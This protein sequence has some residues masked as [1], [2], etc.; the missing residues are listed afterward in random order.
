MEPGIID[1]V[2][3]V[4]YNIFRKE[5]IIE[6]ENKVTITLV[7]RPPSPL[8]KTLEGSRT[9][10]AFEMGAEGVVSMPLHTLTAEDY[11]AIIQDYIM[12]R[13]ENVAKLPSI[14]SIEKLLGKP[15]IQDVLSIEELLDNCWEI[16]VRKSYLPVLAEILH[17]KF[18]GSSIDNNYISWKPSKIYDKTICRALNLESE[19]IA[20]ERWQERVR[21]SRWTIAQVFYIHKEYFRSKGT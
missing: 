4:N 21:K 5:Y 2:N 20:L 14:D 13:V 6:N 1:M 8:N 17:D 19:K 15:S 3:F 16:I 7:A 9:I 11:L 12:I 10:A 18:P